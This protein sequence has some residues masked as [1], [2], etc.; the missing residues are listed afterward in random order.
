MIKGFLRLLEV[1]SGLKPKNV[2]TMKIKLHSG[3]DPQRTRAFYQQLIERI[4]AIPG[5]DAAGAT[6]MLPLGG[7]NRIYTFRKEG[8]STEDPAEIANFRVVTT[9][10]FHAIGT[11]LMRGREFAETDTDGKPLV[12][13]INESMARRFWPY[14]DPIGKRLIIRNGPIP[15]EIVGVVTDVKHFGLEKTA[16]PEM[17][18]SHA[19]FPAGA[20]AVVVHTTS[21][22]LSVVSAIKNQVKALDKNQPIASIK[23]MEQIIADSLSQKRFTILLLSFFAGIALVLVVVGIYGVIA[24]TVAQRTREIGIRMSLGA[25]PGDVFRMIMGQAMVL[26][27]VG[28][29]LGLAAALAVT[30]VMSSLLYGVNS[31]DATTYIG[32]SVMLV[33]VAV[34]ASYF[35]ARRGAKVDPMVAMRH[36]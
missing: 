15:H 7:D 2:L 14:E 19:Q 33:M 8:D 22:P 18:V 10:Y 30:R 31:Y 35:P 21:D 1:N 27:F 11:S 23:T 13:V 5:V 24:C 20:M 16:E 25:Q 26:A 4:E 28:I 29:G 12:L 9:N 6:F 36:E 17:Y 32:I 34:A 3:Y